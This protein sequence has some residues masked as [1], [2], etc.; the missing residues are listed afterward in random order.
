MIVIDVETTGEIPWENSILSIGAIDFSNPSN[1]FYKECR[2][3]DGAIVDPAALKING[4]SE[5]DITS[6]KKESL[7]DLLKGFLEWTGKIKDTTL[8][9]HNHYMDVYFIEYSLKLYGLKSHCK[10]RLVDTHT[11]AYVH[12]LSRGLDVPMAGNGSGIT[13]DI[14]FNY[15]GLPTEPK[16]HNGLTGAKLEAEALSRLIYGKNLLKDY[17]EFKIPQYLKK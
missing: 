3:R 13:S 7:E 1:Q 10:Y 6:K 17:K 8:A 16:P 5:A 4:F 2:M 15:C 14:F 12:H 11:L 9:G